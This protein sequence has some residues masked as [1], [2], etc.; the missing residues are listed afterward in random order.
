MSSFIDYIENTFAD[1]ANNDTLYRYKRLVLDKM[2]ER[3]NEVTHTG[4]HDEKV[5]DDLIISEF[6]HLKENYQKF[7]AEDR[8]R[9]KE[10]ALNKFMIFGTFGF[11]LVLVVLYL[12]ISFLTHAWSQTWLLIVG[13]ILLWVIFLFS[14]F[15]RRITA[16]RRLFHPIARVLLALSVM[17]GTTVVFLF[18][19]VALHWSDAW[20]LYPLGVML[21][22][23]AD[24]IYA[25]VTK[26]KLRIINYLIYIPAGMP[27][28]YVALGGLHI[29]PWHPG[30]LLMPLSVLIDLVLIV[31]RSVNNAKYRYKQEVDDEWN[32]N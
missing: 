10:K 11:I 13:G 26:Q 5:L 2:T 20:V 14:V 30:W 29:L 15:I 16:L 19:L 27:M 32:A 8:H 6:P 24:G 31:L 23:I 25:Y 7:C 28:L 4:L 17:A 12:A 22:Y 21:L 9:R 1:T 18:A 3:A